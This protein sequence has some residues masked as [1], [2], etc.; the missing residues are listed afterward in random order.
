MGKVE[1]KFR[2]V[3]NWGSVEDKVRVMMER[4]E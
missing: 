3:L 4:G 2:K 1:L